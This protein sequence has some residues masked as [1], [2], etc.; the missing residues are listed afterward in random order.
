[1]DETGIEDAPWNRAAASVLRGLDA[2]VGMLLELAELRGAAVLVVSD[3]GFG[4]CLGRIHVNRI[5]IE[6]GLARMP[7]ASGRISRRLKQGLD[8]L[9]LWHAKRDDP[10]ARSASFELSIAAQFPFDWSRTRAFAPHQD[11]AAMIYL[12]R[13]GQLNTTPRQRDETLREAAEA[14]AAA[15]HETTGKPLFPTVINLAER[16]RIDPVVEGC[17]DLLALPD[18][19]YWVRTKLGPGRSWVEPDAN[20]PGTHRPEGVVALRAP[21]VASGRSLRANLQDIAPSILSLFGVPIPAH[22]E[23]TPLA[24]LP[25][26]QAGTIRL[27]PGTPAFQGPHQPQFD[28]TEE[29]QAI[30]EQRLADLGYLE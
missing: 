26:T 20:L 9:R 8:H 1:V 29:E 18:E 19:A 23:G 2:A 28:Y 16:Y 10:Q 12:N 11:T 25:Q 4:P 6:A 3:H 30:I 24:C 17:P 5:L 13:S 21:G 7:G 22:I 14:L 15:Q 27:D